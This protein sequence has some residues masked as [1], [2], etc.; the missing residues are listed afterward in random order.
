MRNLSKLVIVES[1]AKAK[2]IGKY[3]GKDYKV[4]ASVGHI[5][6]LPKS[7]LGV[8]VD[9]DFL[10]LYENKKDK[11]NVIKEL[12][13]KA[14]DSESIFL[15]TDPDREGE[16]IAWHLANILELDEH[17]QNRVTFNEITKNGVQSGMKNPRQL[18]LD[19]INSQQA[20]RILDRL[21]GYKLSPFLWKKVRRGL[22]A[23]RVQSVAVRIIVDREKEIEAFI[24]HEYWSVDAKLLKDSADSLFNAKLVEAKGEKIDSGANCTLTS[25]ARTDDILAELKNAE[26]VVGKVKKSKRKKQPSPPFTTSTLQQEAS[27]KL[28]FGSMRTMRA[29]QDLYE[30]VNVHGHGAVGLITY[31]RTDSIRVSD[32]AANAASTLIEQRYG[33]EYLPDKP[34][35]FKTKNNNANAQDAHE[36]I[37]PSSVHLKPDDIKDSLTPDQYKLYKLIWS[38]F[39]ASRMSEAVFDSVVSDIENGAYVFRAT[40]SKLKFDGF[41]KVYQTA[42]EEDEG[43]MLPDLSVGEGLDEKDVTAEQ[44]FTQPP[45]RFTEAS[46]V[47]ELEEKNIGRPSTFVPIVA[48]LTERR[49][50]VERDKKALMP[51]EL[52]FV[53]TELMEKY[54]KEIVDAGFTAGMEDKLDDIEADGRNW[55]GIVAEFY[56]VLKDEL[57]VADDEIEKIIIEDEPTDEIC[58]LCGKPMVIKQGR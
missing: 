49:G 39:M 13:A 40:G 26:Y 55:Q 47:K 45:P 6:D 10:P 12:K 51:T 32:E 30:G 2:T 36:A 1:P 31:I 33:K 44:G 29:A 16:A 9:N 24:P 56:D 46:L 19:L 15:A 21:L 58:E 41:L 7:K 4:I 35:F 50:Y 34:H 14:K 43:N 5:R 20:R 28:S 52:G 18:D 17:E 3:L 23:G 22:S 53:V 57:K 25:K 27:G 38:R 54:F 37:R 11:S 48:T 42:L 8:D